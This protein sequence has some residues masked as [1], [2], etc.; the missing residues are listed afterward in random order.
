MIQVFFNI[1]NSSNHLISDVIRGPNSLGSLFEIYGYS[2]LPSSISPSPEG[3]RYFSG[4]YNTVVYGTNSDYNFNAIKLEFPYPTIR[5]NQNSINT[6]A[7]V[8]SSVIHDYFIT[9]FNIDLF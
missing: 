3:M 8:F 2:A 5:D 4:G 9:Y 6:F 7:E 1:L